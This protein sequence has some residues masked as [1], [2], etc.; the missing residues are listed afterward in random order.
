VSVEYPFPFTMP[1]IQEIFPG[2]YLRLRIHDTH[3]I[4]APECQ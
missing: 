4:L 2:G 1:M 3:T